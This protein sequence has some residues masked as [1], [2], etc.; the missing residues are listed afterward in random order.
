[1]VRERGSQCNAMK[2]EEVGAGRNHSDRRALE[3]E[4]DDTM[5][6]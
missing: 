4:D 1:M 3:V 2:K 6:A 5:G